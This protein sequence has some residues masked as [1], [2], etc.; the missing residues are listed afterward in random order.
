MGQRIE[1][2]SRVPTLEVGVKMAEGTNSPGQLG[3]ADTVFQKV[4][5]WWPDKGGCTGEGY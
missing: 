2:E 3:P 5:L 1:E 4:A